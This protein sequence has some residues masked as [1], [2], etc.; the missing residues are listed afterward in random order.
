MT[1][2]DDDLLAVAGDDRVIRMHDARTGRTLHARSGHRGPVAAVA[3]FADRPVVLSAA[4]DGD[5][6]IWDAGGGED[7]G[8]LAFGEGGLTGL[9]H[10]RVADRDLVC[11]AFDDGDVRVR[12]ADDPGTAATLRGHTGWVTALAADGDGG[13]LASGGADGVVRLWALPG[14]R[15]L[16][17]LEGHTGTV[18]GVALAT[19]G[20][21]TFVGSCSLD[22]TV[23]TWDART[24]E[25]LAARPAPGD[26]LSAISF[27]EAE[28][29]PA[30]VTAGTDGGV[31]LWDVLT[32]API[33]VLAEEP[34]GC[35]A[36]TSADGRRLVAAGDKT[37]LVRIWSDGVL[38]HTIPASD[39]A[40]TAVAFASGGRLVSG[41]DDGAVRVHDAVS[42]EEVRTPTPHTAP[43]LALAF[44]GD[45]LVSGGADAAVR[46]WDARSG[47]PRARL[48]GHTS[49]VAAVATGVVGGRTVI[50]SAGYDR[51][52][53][54]WDAESGAPSL[55]IHGHMYPVYAL[56]FG[57]GLLA[58]AGYDGVVR[59]WDAATGAQV[60]TLPGHDG[61]VRALC[62]GG[63][64]LAVA[65]GDGAVRLWRLPEGE[66]AGEADVAQTPLAAAFANGRLQVA[67][68]RG[69]TVV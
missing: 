58:S 45:L 66:P 1:S 2:G 19:A 3:A 41:T 17:A 53:R 46:V 40:V 64:V 43:V 67:G 9:C 30:V 25:P 59:V 47:V 35:V 22:G 60:V 18:T 63:G 27:T 31:R 42:G 44:T 10:A 11:A 15:E 52:V 49:A 14:G 68:T 4:E 6:R 54:T 62:F 7:L 55:A 57:D 12:D 39:G 13:L 24:G 56:A 37:G 36:T 69:L 61:P 29:A 34:A 8:T 50:A 33:A 65:S 32:G 26:W 23:R 16:H 51:V 38:A 48:L 5:V 21:R 28:G 20:D